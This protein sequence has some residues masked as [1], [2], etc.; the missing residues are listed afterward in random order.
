MELTNM[1][2]IQD[3]ETGKVVV[4]DR[5]KSWKGISFPGGHVEE[6]ESFVDSAVR[7]VEEETGLKI[8]NLQSCGFM[9]WVNNK[10]FDRYL[11]FFY[12]TQDYKGELIDQT[13]EGKVFWTDICEIYNMNLAPNFKEY[14]KMFLD[15]TYNEAFSSWNDDEPYEIIFK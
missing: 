5:I 9:H 6:G 12:K 1:V 14:L 7:E 10:T 8:T 11:T 13:D 3:K 4:Q 2:M 15:D